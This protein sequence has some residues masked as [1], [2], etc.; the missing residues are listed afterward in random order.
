MFIPQLYSPLQLHLYLSTGI[1]GRSG[2]QIW[3]PTRMQM[4]LESGS[5][6]R[7]G[8]NYKMSRHICNRSSPPTGIY[9]I[10]C[11]LFRS[12][13]EFPAAPL[14]VCPETWPR[15]ADKPLWQS[16]C[17]EVNLFHISQPLSLF[18]SA[19][20]LYLCFISWSTQFSDHGEEQIRL[21]FPNSL[22]S[23][24]LLCIPYKNIKSSLISEN[25][26]HGGIDPL[27]CSMFQ[28]LPFGSFSIS[29]VVCIFAFAICFW[30]RSSP[31]WPFRVQLI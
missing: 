4:N 24:E 6:C 13:L 5:L 22:I 12:F 19:L 17:F 14:S 23:D 11:T 16:S 31:V 7:H 21:W 28:I 30:K 15:D 27:A 18:W 20:V 29:L 9:L 26:E 1:P 2:W 8:Y 3:H 10:L 25:I